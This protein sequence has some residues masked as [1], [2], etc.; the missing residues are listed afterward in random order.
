[1]KLQQSLKHSLT[2]KD[3]N[4]KLEALKKESKV[5]DAHGGS[6]FT[7][8]AMWNQSSGPVRAVLLV[9]VYDGCLFWSS[10]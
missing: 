6:H 2:S 4:E 9:V 3:T 10:N 7:V 8:K 5:E 1:M